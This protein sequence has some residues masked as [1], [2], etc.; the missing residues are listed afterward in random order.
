[1]PRLEQLVRDHG[2]RFPDRRDEWQSYLFY[3]RDFADASGRLPSSFD[4]LL[5]EVFAP[6]AR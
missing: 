6:L 5:D 4:A 2:E 3:L 1:M